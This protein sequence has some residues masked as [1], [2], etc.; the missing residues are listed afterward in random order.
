MPHTRFQA[1]Q[2]YLGQ[3]RLQRIA[4]NGPLAQGTTKDEGGAPSTVSITSRGEQPA[5]SAVTATTEDTRASG[6]EPIR[7]RRSIP[8]SVAA[9]AIRPPCDAPANT[10]GLAKVGGE[11]SDHREPFVAHPFAA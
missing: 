11:P 3:H 5:S 2:S 8:A 7:R 6:D 1:C 4:A 10:S 9:N